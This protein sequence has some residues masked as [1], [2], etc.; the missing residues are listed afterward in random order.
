MPLTVE[1]PAT[2]DS[3]ILCEISSLWSGGGTSKFLGPPYTTEKSATNATPV[4]RTEDLILNEW[5]EL[6]TRMKENMPVLKRHKI[7]I[8]SSINLHI[9]TVEPLIRE[10]IGADIVH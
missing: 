10:G 2:R 8:G 5:R 6:G 9:L 4:L 7:Y 3:P 1:A